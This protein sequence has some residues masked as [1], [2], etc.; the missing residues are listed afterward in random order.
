MT[1]AGSPWLQCLVG[2]PSCPSMPAS[3]SPSPSE[4]HVHTSGRDLLSHCPPSAAP[5]THW[6][7]VKAACLTHIKGPV[8]LAPAHPSCIP[9][10]TLSS[11]GTSLF[12]SPAMAQLTTPS[13]LLSLCPWNVLQQLPRQTNSSSKTQVNP[14]L[15]QEDLLSLNTLCP[16]A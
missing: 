14:H 2:C 10:P 9:A 6:G 1:T 3:P 15:P 11:L 4:L 13:P 5:I 7:R 8:N 12:S 16:A